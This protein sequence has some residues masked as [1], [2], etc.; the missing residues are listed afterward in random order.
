MAKDE[1]TILDTEE[2]ILDSDETILDSDAAD[3]TLPDNDDA[4]MLNDATVLDGVTTSDDGSGMPVIEKG[5]SLLD[6]YRIE[7]DAIEGGMGAVWRV[8]HTGW[9]VDLAMKR[10]KAGMFQTEKQKENF[11]QECDAWIKLGLHPNIVSCYYV[12]RIGDTPTI[13]SEWMDGGSLKNAINDGRLYE[14]N[15]AERILDIAIQFARG[16]HYA[17]EYR[18][19]DGNPKGLIHQDVKPDNLLLTKDWDAKVADFGIARARA[20]LTVLDAD[21][22]TDATMFSASGGYTPAYCSMEQM[23]GEQLTRRTDI[24][25]WAVSV[26]EMYLGD[27]PWQNGVIA[28]AAC[29]EY[30]P[31]AKVSI[32]QKM[33]DLLK[34]CL[35]AK[36]IERPH[37]FAEI[38]KRLLV[39]Y[40]EETQEEYPRPV[41]KA[42]A[43]TADSLNN[44]ALSMLDLGKA[45]EAEK[46]WERA[47]KADT[48]HAQTLYN[49][50]LHLWQTG[51]ID[52]EQ[53]GIQL[54]AMHPGIPGDELHQ[55]FDGMRG[56]KQACKVS[57][58]KILPYGEAVC[59]LPAEQPLVFASGTEP[60]EEI[61]EVLGKPKPITIEEG[62]IVSV[63]PNGG[64]VAPWVAMTGGRFK[65]LSVSPRRSYLFW[66][67]VRKSAGLYDLKTRRLMD[68][69]PNPYAQSASMSEDERALYICEGDRV[70]QYGMESQREENSYS[71]QNISGRFCLNKD[72]T[73]VVGYESPRREIHRLKAVDVRT[74]EPV[75]DIQLPSQLSFVCLNADGANLYAACSDGI[76]VLR[77]KDATVLRHIGCQ[78]DLFSAYCAYG[79]EHLLIS[80]KNKCA[81]KLI[82]TASGVCERTFLSGTNT[83]D[84]VV[85]LCALDG[86]NGFLSLSKAGKLTH[87]KYEKPNQAPSWVISR[88]ASFHETLRK[89]ELFSA[90]LL[91]AES[92]NTCG[93]FSA[94]IRYL[95]KARA[96]PGY[97]ADVRAL[98]LYRK[99][100]PSCRKK[101]PCS[102]VS[103]TDM[104]YDNPVSLSVSPD[105]AL[106]FDYLTNQVYDVAENTFHSMM[107]TSYH[108][109][110]VGSLLD[111][112][113]IAYC[114]CQEKSL[115]AAIYDV[116]SGE[117]IREI[118]VKQ[119]ISE[120]RELRVHITLDGRLLSVDWIGLVSSG[121]A[122]VDTQ[123]GKV[124]PHILSFINA[125]AP[126]C[127]LSKQCMVCE[128]LFHRLH[129]YHVPTGHSKKRM[130][131][132]LGKKAVSELCADEEEKYL[133]VTI[134]EAERN[135]L[136]IL[137]IASGKVMNTLEL[138]DGNCRLHPG[139]WVTV[140][141]AD[142]AVL[143]WRLADMALCRN[144]PKPFVLPVNAKNADIMLSH[145]GM[146]LLI[147]R[148]YDFRG[149]NGGKAEIFLMDWSLETE[150][151]PKEKTELRTEESG[152]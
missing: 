99:L 40:R 55:R 22:P 53:A 109:P 120:L 140:L 11:I 32:P 135:T 65:N 93:D 57:V 59:F 77:A 125:G 122:A 147:K 47:L 96:I 50:A 146:T 118:C 68:D 95:D 18:D 20:T 58:L 78:T 26:M 97:S 145:N 67:L 75:F 115:M 4:T 117:R 9:N 113:H 107:N 64:L 43:D 142:G 94:A 25:S 134:S 103:L 91:H 37:D 69:F 39:I 131:I 111:A 63:V 112:E 85:S 33:Q 49:R 90:E 16:L 121:S 10:P 84:E 29:E 149:P 35:N 98:A 88:I 5:A 137:D 138:P 28:G 81:I 34:A 21:I 71:F 100:F 116:R 101:F 139:G 41:S 70:V 14:G 150:S 48:T 124:I 66:T 92:S 46:C 151:P 61:H 13:F 152:R 45:E 6:T 7:S 30:F 144:T 23:N 31:D 72:G 52:D 82:N 132:D 60:H 2:T 126:A 76:L 110:F 15:A 83:G 105:G 141:T 80:G 73:I 136:Y 86:D 44:R 133:G 1:K 143:V 102:C 114:F 79:K 74:G 62:Q 108:Y 51:Q 127:M 19:E 3:A 104:A 148:P 119:K 17:H 56:E 128:D 129:I 123:D 8:Y 27:R 38:E 54:D 106:V 130:R 87:W 42:A 12:R 24:Y 36:E 89:E